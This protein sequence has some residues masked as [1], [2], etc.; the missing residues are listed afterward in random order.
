MESSPL[1][2]VSRL[3]EGILRLAGSAGALFTLLLLA[4]L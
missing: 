3:C 4:W 2:R 1:C